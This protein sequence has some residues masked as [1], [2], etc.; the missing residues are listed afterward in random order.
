L[1]CEPW[2]GAIDY[3][4][5]QFHA[6]VKLITVSFQSLSEV[7]LLREFLSGRV[8]HTKA[9]ITVGEAL[10]FS[11]HSNVGLGIAIKKLLL[12][13]T[14]DH[15]SIELPQMADLE[16]DFRRGWHFWKN[17]LRI[18]KT[19]VTYQ[20]FRDQT[21]YAEF[22]LASKLLKSALIRARLHVS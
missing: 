6:L 7:L 10:P 19:F 12:G 17:L 3:D 5:S 15:I 16:L 4:L 2:T 9:L 8:N 21:F 20:S 11:S 1:K 14:L 22:I 18:L 13:E